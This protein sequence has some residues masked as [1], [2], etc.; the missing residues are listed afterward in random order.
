MGLLGSRKAKRSPLAAPPHL[1][2]QKKEPSQQQ[3]QAPLKRKIFIN[4][5]GPILDGIKD[6]LK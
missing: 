4:F 2:S 5:A 6:L 3:P 1:D